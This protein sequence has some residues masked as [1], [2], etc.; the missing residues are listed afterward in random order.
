MA[1]LFAAMAWI[2]CQNTLEP[3]GP[4]RPEDKPEAVKDSVKLTI[5]AGKTLDTKAL[6]LVNE[7]K[8]LNAFWNE[9]EVVKVFTLDSESPIGTLTATPKEDKTQATL[10]GSINVTGLAAGQK[11]I[12]LFPKETWS[13]VGQS[14]NLTSIASN[15]DFARAEVTITEVSPTS[16]ITGSSTTFVN[17]QSIFRFGFRHGSGGPTIRTKT[18]LLTSNQG[19]LAKTVTATTGANTYYEADEPMIIDLPVAVSAAEAAANKLLYFAIRNG[20]T[21]A[22]DTFSFTIYDDDGA[23]F[24]GSKLIP[25]T[26]VANPFVSAKNVGMARL[27]LPQGDTEV[28]TAL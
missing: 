14:G 19:K 1:A 25:S 15:F 11:L 17:Q 6:E 13:Y 27:E 4:E 22:D 28:T 5:E 26:H 20:N 10:S 8:T 9:G 21:S 7:E 2:G 16:I 24:K 23:T 12:L 3:E 18:V